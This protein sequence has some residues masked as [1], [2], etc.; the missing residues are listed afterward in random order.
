[1]DSQTYQYAE[2]FFPW[3]LQHYVFNTTIFP[4]WSD[5]AVYYFQQNAKAKVLVR[6]DISTGK[7]ESILDYQRLV[8]AL[9]E[10]VNHEINSEKLPLDRFSIQENPRRL[11][12]CYEDSQWCYDLEKNTCTKEVGVNPERLESPDK[13][14]ALWIKDHNLVLTDLSHHQDFAL[15]EDGELYYDYASSPETNTQAVTA[16]LRNTLSAPVALWSPDSSKLITHKLNQKSVNEL[17]LLQS[18]P[19]NSQRPRPHSYR[20]SFTGDDHLP[21]AELI[22]VDISTKTITPIKTD[23]FISPYLTPLEFKFVWWNDSSN[24]VYFLRETR[25][26]K[27]IMLCVADANMGETKI[28]ITETAETYVEPS[29]LFPCPPQVLI[30][31]DKQGIVW[32]SERS[33]YSHLYLYDIGKDT[34]KCAITQGEWCVREVHHYD[35]KENWLYFTACGYDKNADPYYKQ[36]YRCRLDGSVMTCLSAENANHTISIAPNKNCFLDTYSTIIIQLAMNK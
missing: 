29:Q 23:P 8:D 15:T 16:R 4:Y 11:C 13:N 1:M 9:S 32:L 12:F 31:E 25:G 14:W 26:S 24:K 22:I 3:N 33:G 6:I 30:L 36:L 10:Q 2:R 19:E 17:F 35:A 27:E 7:K 5:D 34:I 20:M 21:V 28:L 18:A